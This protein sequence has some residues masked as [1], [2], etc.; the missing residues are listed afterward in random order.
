MARRTPWR[1]G[2]G[3]CSRGWSPTER[4]LQTLVATATYSPVTMA[5]GAADLID[6]AANSKITGEGEGYS[7]TDFIVF[8]ANVDGAMEVVDL[9]K[10]YLEK[11]RPSVIKASR[12]TQ[13]VENAITKYKATPGS[14]TPATSN[15]RPCWTPSGDKYP[16]Q[17]PGLR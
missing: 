15:T 4:Q 10:P 2:A 12:T 13:A 5:S 8:Q 16:A 14:T 3:Y 11:R 9:I 6:E 1:T 17:G 7:N